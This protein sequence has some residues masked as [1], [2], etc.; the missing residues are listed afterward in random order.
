MPSN[1]YKAFQANAKDIEKLLLLHE[2][3]SGTK[4]GRRYGLEVLNK[5]AIVLITS[6]WEAY[7]ED[8]VSAGIECLVEKAPSSE[9]LPTS[10]KRL[11]AKELKENKHELSIWELSG[12]GW[13]KVLRDRLDILQNKRNRKLNTPKSSN[14]IEMFNDGIGILDISSRWRWPTQMT[15]ERARKKLDRYVD[16]RNQIAHRGGALKPVTK[17]QVKDYFDFIQKIVNHT[18]G[19]I[20]IHIRQITGKHLFTR[21]GQA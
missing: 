1:A 9:K 21:A 4:A 3:E 20:N 2:G 19:G 11:I 6:Y 7:C 15:P 10:L 14:I 5:S 12:E 8:I 18:G 17:A 13:R 16:L